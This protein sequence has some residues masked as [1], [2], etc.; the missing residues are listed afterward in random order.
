M[1][2]CHTHTHTHRKWTGS[3][4]SGATEICFTYHLENLNPDDAKDICSW[5]PREQNCPCSLGGSD[6][7]LSLTCQSVALCQSWAPVSTCVQ[8]GRKAFSSVSVTLPCDML[9]SHVSEETCVNLPWL[10][11]C[12]I[13]MSWLVGDNWWVTKLGRKFLKNCLKKER[14][15]M[16]VF[17]LA[18]LMWT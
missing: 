18:V 14:K 2:L 9:A 3:L 12:L 6:G 4:L 15:W 16:V 8:K 11:H 1:S 13:G 5:K 17:K 10:G 7:M